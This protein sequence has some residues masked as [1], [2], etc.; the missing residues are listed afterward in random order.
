MLAQHQFGVKL[1]WPWLAD[2]W[3]DDRVLVTRRRRPRD[4]FC[5]ESNLR[6]VDSAD[7][8][9]T[10]PVATRRRPQSRKLPCCLP[11]DLLNITAAP[12]YHRAR[13]YIVISCVLKDG[14]IYCI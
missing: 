8:D 6:D 10:H 14:S 1:W 7:R 3:L 2:W 9:L 11:I 13:N 5:R 4:S 12:V